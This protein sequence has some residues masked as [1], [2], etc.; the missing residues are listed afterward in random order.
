[1][2]RE[3]RSELDVEKVQHYH[4]DIFNEEKQQGDTKIFA[5][6]VA[7]SDVYIDQVWLT[8]AVQIPSQGRS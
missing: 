8:R 6:P 5:P 7:K 1:M 4:K 3:E 2:T